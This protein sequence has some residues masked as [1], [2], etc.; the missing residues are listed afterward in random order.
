MEFDLCIVG[1]GTAG[2]AAAYA[3][4]RTGLRVAVIEKNKDLG[5]TAVNAW[6]ETW[7]EGINPPYL[8]EL[9]NALCGTGKAWGN[10][11]N[12]WLP[13]KFAKNGTSSFLR[14]DPAAL[15]EKYAGDFSDDGHF[16]FFT[17]C[18]AVNAIKKDPRTVES[19]EIVNLNT[20]EHFLIRAKFFIDASGD[21][22]LCRH[23]GSTAFYGEDPY[24]RFN[25]PLMR[26]KDGNTKYL[27]EPSLFFR[28]KEEPAPAVHASS[29]GGFNYDG[30]ID[31]FHLWVNPMSGLGLTGLEI[32]QNGS[33]A[34]YKKA[35]SLV[36]GFW[37]YIK[38][39]HTRRKNAG[40]PLYYPDDVLNCI[41]TGEYAPMLGIRESYRIECD[42]MIRQ[43]DLS[44]K[45]KSDNPGNFIACGSHDIDFHVYGSLNPAEVR[46]FNRDSLKPSGI[47]YL[48]I[49]PKALDNVLI[50]CRAY[51]ASHIALAARRVNK[52][53]AQLGWAAGHALR[54]CMEDRLT[55]TREVNIQKLQSNTYTGFAASVQE[56]ENR[57]K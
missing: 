5:G 23:A 43:Q 45:I 37:D 51:G 15:A 31:R 33:E 49:V 17:Q 42:Y 4:R 50:A 3:L 25:E 26:G 16:R 6:V 57:M 12:S 29:A 40:E 32:I 46:A 14:F 53:M 10:L 30:Y 36:G 2:M 11:N 18:M 38:R 24:S 35:V 52:D 55:N 19:V 39:E 44:Q 41:P 8:V 56:L 21:G 47:P 22:I 9:F 20:Q 27:N 1:A 7:I 48:S 13:E 28:I 54:I 34:G